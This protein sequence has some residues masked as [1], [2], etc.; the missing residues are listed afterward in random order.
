MLDLGTKIKVI[1][2]H[3]KGESAHGIARSLSVGKTQIHKIVNNKDAIREK[4][5]SGTYSADRKVM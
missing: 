2:H 5:S 3:E 1:E 4:W